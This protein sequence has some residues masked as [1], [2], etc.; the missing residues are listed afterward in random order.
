MYIFN[1]YI[2]IYHPCIIF[3]AGYGWFGG[4]VL[5]FNNQIRVYHVLFTDGTTGY[6]AA[7]D[8]VT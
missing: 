7:E 6:A 3:L 8:F 1:I 4:E 2:Y 5:Y